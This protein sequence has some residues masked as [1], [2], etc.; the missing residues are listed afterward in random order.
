MNNS[1]II[2][3]I[4][5]ELAE[6]NPDTLVH[7]LEI[8]RQSKQKQF[9]VSEGERT[10]A[11]P[12]QEKAPAIQLLQFKGEN[13]PY[14]TI[15]KLSVKE[16]GAMQRRLKEQ[17]KKWLQ[18]KYASLNAVWLMVMDGQI[19]AW[20]KTTK[21]YP[22][23]AKITEICRKT[24]KY[25]FIFI[26]DNVMAIE[27]SASAWHPLEDNDF[28]PTVPVSFNSDLGKA[29]LIADFDTGSAL[30]FVNF[31]F[32]LA[33]KVVHH[34]IDEYIENSVHLNQ[35]YECSLKT[36]TVTMA[37]KSG[38]AVSLE[39]EVY[40][41][42]N[43][44]NSPFVKI[45]PNRIALIGRNLLLQFKLSTLLNFDKRQTGILLSPP[46]RGRKKRNQNSV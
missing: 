23:P 24:G 46:K 10:I 32:L 11:L 6:A 45:N 31:D 9:S 27:E 21:N 14:E 5:T 33:R 20:G 26:N 30:S 18:E 37:L 7:L 15:E 29:S 25:P 16:R 40:C 22:K 13:L 42:E 2:E 8:L 1:A 17:N 28:Y 41:V 39:T 43:W 3:T 4:K 36:V 34:E 35:P 12:F 19:L 38:E 44:S